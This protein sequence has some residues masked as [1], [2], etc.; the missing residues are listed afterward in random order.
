[1]FIQIL[2]AKR[3]KLLFSCCSFGNIVFVCDLHPFFFFLSSFFSEPSK[4][5]FSLL[6]RFW[7]FLSSRPLKFWASVSPLHLRPSCPSASTT[8]LDEAPPS[9]PWIKFQVTVKKGERQ[10]LQLLYGTVSVVTFAP[11]AFISPAGHK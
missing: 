6:Q 8:R 11:A 5:P 1:M 10:A 2:Y 9:P 7:T 4:P 3:F